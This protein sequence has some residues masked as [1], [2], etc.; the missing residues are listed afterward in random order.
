MQCLPLPDF[1]TSASLELMLFA[2]RLVFLGAILTLGGLVN[3]QVW[4]RWLG[5]S[6]IGSDDPKSFPAWVDFIVTN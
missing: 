2:S 5:C 1:I 6:E 4:I 3:T